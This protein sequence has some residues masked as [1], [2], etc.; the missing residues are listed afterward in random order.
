V[1]DRR[2]PERLAGL[3]TAQPGTL[4]TIARKAERLRRATEALQGELGPPLAEHCVVAALDPEVVVQTDA[5]VWA[6]R[7]RFLASAVRTALAP[8]LEGARD[9]EVRV[10]VRPPEVL[11]RPAGAAPRPTLSREAGQRV[12]QAAQ[13]I[14]DPRL[15]DALLRLAGRSARQR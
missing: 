12:R 5:A 14:A 8:L 4:G 7:L 1:S 11:G 2:H 13:S 9:V 15:R 3:L 10:T 6:S